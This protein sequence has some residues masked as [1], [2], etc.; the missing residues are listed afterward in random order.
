[1]MGL[2]KPADWVANWIEPD[3]QEDVSKPGPVP[4]LRKE[5]K[6][7]GTVEKARVYVTSHGLYSMSIN[8]TT[9]SDQLFTPGWTSYNKR[10]QYQT[11]D[12]TDLLQRGDNAVAVLLGSGWY[13]GEIG[14]R[15]KRNFYGEHVALLCQ[16]QIRY[17]DGHEETIVSD[18]GWKSSTGPLLMSEIY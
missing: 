11:Y 17:K 3:L 16:I 13:R 5:F 6:L 8:G 4:M 15:N 2:L 7:S 9:V 10:L 18:R 1:E 14:F 12:V